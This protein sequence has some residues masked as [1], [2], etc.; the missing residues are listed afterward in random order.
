MTSFCLRSKLNVTTLEDSCHRIARE[1]SCPPFVAAILEMQGRV[2]LHDIDKARAW[3]SPSLDFFA[4]SCFLGE[5]ARAVAERWQR[6]S[7][8]GNVVVY[9]DYDVDGVS[10]T[11]LAM[12]LCKER[13]AGVRYYIPHRHMEGYGLHRQVVQQLLVAGCDTLIIVDC[14]TKDGDIL[15]E[16]QQTGMNVFVFDHHLPEKGELPASFIV[17]PQ[18]DGDKEGKLLC[19]TAVLWLWAYQFKIMPMEWLAEHLDLVALATIADC[20]TLGSLNRA[21]VKEGLERI[22]YTARPGLELLIKRLGLFHRFVNE[23][24]L[25]MKVIPCL[26]AA[27]RLAFADLAVKV[28]TGE[29]PVENHVEELISLNRKRQNLSTRITKE[30]VKVVEERSKHVLFEE[31]WPVGVLSGVASRLCSEKNAPVVL[32]APVQ[33]W[34]RGTVRMPEGGNA[35]Q[36]LDHLSDQLEAWGGHKQAA[37]FSVSKD[38]WEKLRGDLEHILASVEYEDPE[39]SALALHPSQ[40]T[41]QD[42]KSALDLGP[43]GMGNPCPLLYC[44]SYGNEQFLPLG[45]TGLHLKIQ[46]GS[47]YLVAF[48]SVEILKTLSSSH[49]TGWVY[50][51]RVDFWRGQPRLQFMLDYIVLDS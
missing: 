34:I 24:Q 11:T 43:F 25:A 35:V 28:L 37:G 10:S 32:A 46:L 5:G 8:L 47:E 14:G 27:G 42:W 45:K 20:M 21:L 39:I 31:S 51:P 22:R 13:A 15:K 29:E 26:N 33:D 36:V 18:I 19:A 49:I 50:H 23:E 12:E 1:L 16:A 38:N 48:N 2:S 6:L 41:L 40:I 17:N 30:A 9:G 3:L 4:A 7:S 44:E